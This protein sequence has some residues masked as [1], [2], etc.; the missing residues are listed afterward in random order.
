MPYD[1]S[2]KLVIGI[3]SR[4]LFDL[5]VENAI[6]DEQGVETYADYQRA[7]ENDPLQPGTAFPLV[8][9]LLRLNDLIPERR[10]VEVVVISRNTPDTGLRA[11]NAITAHKLDISRAAFTGGGPTAPYLQAFKIDLFL[12]RDTGDVQEAIDAGVAAAQLYA[13]PLDYSAP[14]NQIRIAFDGDA[15]LFSAESERIFAEKGLEVRR[16][17]PPEDRDER[18]LPG[19]EGADRE[20]RHLL[21]SP[22]PVG[23][24]RSGAHGQDA[25]EQQ[26]ALIAPRGEVSVRGGREAEVGLPLLVDVRQA[27]GQR[28]HVA[29]HGERQPDRVP[30]GRIGV[31]ARDEHTHVREWSL[32]G[33][34]HVRSRG[35]ISV[36]GRLLGAQPFAERRDGVL[37]RGQRLRTSRV[38]QS[39]VG[40][41]RE[42]ASSAH[43]T[44]RT[45]SGP[46]ASRCCADWATGR[47]VTRSRFTW[48]GASRA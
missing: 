1:L 34:Q 11:F 29:V 27:P 24:G 33:A 20:L 36:T 45:R 46:R 30:G 3:S 5:E 8:K 43:S 25:V 23:G 13:A 40:E 14:D 37:H 9:A 47:I 12:S 32:E 48:A 10:L 7:H 39:L 19:H 44:G 4:A 28:P 2:D 31:L 16:V 35:E 26:H 21:P 18:L 22:A 6:Y 17:T 41:F 38:D 42:G 15:V